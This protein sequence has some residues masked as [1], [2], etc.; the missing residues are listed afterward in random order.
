MGND[1]EFDAV[2]AEFRAGRLIPPIDS[3]YGLE[4]G[5]DAFERLASGKQFGKVVLRMV[6]R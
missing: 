4:D 3:V 6:D 2:V 1:A 5:R